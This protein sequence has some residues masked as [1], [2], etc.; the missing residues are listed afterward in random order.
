MSKDQQKIKL[1]EAS[2]FSWNI[3]RI[4][5]VRCTEALT[6]TISL[7]LH[8][9]NTTWTTE[10]LLFKSIYSLQQSQLHQRCSNAQKWQT[11]SI[12]F[13]F[14][15]YCLPRNGSPVSFWKHLSWGSLSQLLKENITEFSMQGS[16]TIVLFP[17][18]KSFSRKWNTVLLSLNKI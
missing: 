5:T 10:S 9:R 17:S 11:K 15:S 18:K 12:S 7:V 2:V 6:S 3:N 8:L 16:T 1:F 13:P 14:P 4:I